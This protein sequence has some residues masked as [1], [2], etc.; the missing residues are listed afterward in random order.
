MLIL[1]FLRK[2]KLKKTLQIFE[3]EYNKNDIEIN[4]LQK[5]NES[6]GKGN[7]IEFFKLFEEIL[8]NC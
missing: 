8:D 6:F 3:K 1:D 4:I 7:R 2:K 5:L